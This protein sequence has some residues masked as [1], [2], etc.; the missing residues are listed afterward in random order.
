[1]RTEAR[2]NEILTRLNYYGFGIMGILHAILFWLAY[3]DAIAASLI[4]LW[5]IEVNELKSLTTAVACGMVIMALSYAW[6]RIGKSKFFKVDAI[7][8]SSKT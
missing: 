4:E 6:H 2:Q 7:K 8:A 3:G 5:Q 1:M